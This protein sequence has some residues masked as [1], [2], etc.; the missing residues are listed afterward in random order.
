MSKTVKR[1]CVAAMFSASGFAATFTWYKLT[2]NHGLDDSNAKPIARLVS[3]VN[4][5]QKKSVAKIIWQAAVDNEV[6]R[7]G[8]AIRT[9]ANSE[10]RIE[11]LGSNTAID[12]EPDSAI[13]LQENDGK[14]S[15]DFLKGNIL[16]KSDAT[17]SG[18]TGRDITL[19]SGSKEIALGKSEVT[20]GKSKTGDLSVQVL[21]G[22][23]AGLEGMNTNKIKILSPL[24]GA[25]VYVNP[26]END[27]A[28][29]S[30][31]PLPAGYQVFAEA[32]TSRDSLRPVP[33]AL[34][35]GEKGSMKANLSVGKGFYRLVARSEDPNLPELTSAVLRTQVIAKIAP[36]PLSPEKEALVTVNKYEPSIE[37]LWSNPAGFEKVILEIATSADL[38]QKVKTEYLTDSTKFIFTPEKGADY[39]WRVSGVLDGRTEVV[40]SSVQKFNLKLLNELLPPVLETPKDNDKIPFDM[41]KQKGLVMSWKSSTGATTYKVLVEKIISENGRTPA[42]SEKVF[43]D[44]GQQLQAQIKDLKPGTYTW[45]VSSIGSNQEV[46]KPAEKRTFS[47][48]TLPVLNWADGKTQDNYYYITLKPSVELKWEK[49]D[50]KATSWNLR[51]YSGNSDI[52]PITKKI[53]TTGAEIALPEEGQY[54]AEVEAIDDRGVVIARSQR[55]DIKVSAAPLLPAPKFATSVPSE[56]EATRGGKA[57]LQWTQVP[58]ANKYMISIKNKNGEIAKEYS[59][60]SEEAALNDL[61]P[62]EYNLSLR[63]VD[64]H[65]RIGPEGETRKLKVPAESNL[66]APKLKGVKIK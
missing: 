9:S 32:G 10:A 21:T 34:S 51:L 43:E 40:S 23:V 2:E 27:F 37:L 13:V 28:Q 18:T 15:L 46:S 66:R 11:F 26:K 36:T 14:L 62:G 33:G 38:K 48:Q 49:G 45:T 35:S 17:S 12:L 52:N 1:L 60:A 63:S 50:A 4:D 61:M 30:W 22:T 56:I 8:E 55:R 16:V 3:T 41:V 47:V 59:M 19:K 29:I 25:P 53:T 54:R 6:L 42:S 7:V 57:S 5:V 31:Q 20:L 64:E 24:P 65:G 58:G 39:Y 44:Q